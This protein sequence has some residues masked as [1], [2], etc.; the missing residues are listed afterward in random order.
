MNDNG[1]PVYDFDESSPL[2]R[3]SHRERRNAELRVFLANGGKL[4]E[5]IDATPQAKEVKAG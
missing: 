3:E 4:S 2:F 1:W 5:Y